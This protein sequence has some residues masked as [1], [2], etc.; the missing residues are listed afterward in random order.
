MNPIHSYREKLPSIKDFGILT[1]I[2]NRKRI[3]KAFNFTSTP[4]AVGYITGADMMIRKKVFDEVGGFDKDFFLYAEECE[5]TY[6]INKFGYKS[7]SVPQAKVIHLEGMSSNEIAEEKGFKPDRFRNFLDGNFLY[8]KKVY[9]ERYAIKFA[10]RYIRFLKI[11]CL[12]GTV[13]RKDCEHEKKKIIII[14]QKLIEWE[15]AIK[16]T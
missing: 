3:D 9:G 15:R 2:L 11:V 14:R 13:V 5:L 12:V 10:K 8:Y 4:K 6:R 16:G 1:K 7:Y